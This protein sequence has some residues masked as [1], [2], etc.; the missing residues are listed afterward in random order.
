MYSHLRYNIKNLINI[1]SP[2][3]NLLV[4]TI[5]FIIDYNISISFIYYLFN[6]N[7]KI[8]KIILIKFNINFKQFI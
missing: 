4:N 6:S 3:Y 2:V 7:I 1:T 5:N 8:L